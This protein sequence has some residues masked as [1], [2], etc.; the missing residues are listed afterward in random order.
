[1]SFIEELEN[2]DLEIPKGGLSAKIALA[3]KEKRPLR[4]KLGLDPTK[5]D[6]HLGH[7]VVLRVL[8]KFLKI[9]AKIFLVV[10]DFTAMIGDPSGRDKTRPPLTHQEIQRNAQTYVEQ[11]GRVL[12]TSKI[13]VVFNST[14]LSKISLE[15]FIKIL[16][17]FNLSEILARDDFKQRFNGGFPIAMHE[18]IYPLMQAYDSYYLK[19]DVEIGG[20]DQLFNMQMGRSLQEAFA[21]SAQVIITTPLLIGIDGVNK[22]SKSLNNYIAITEE[23]KDIYAKILAIP[24]SLIPD[25]LKLV[26]DLPKAKKRELLARL[27]KNVNPFL[28]KKEIAFQIVCQFYDKKAA[29][30][31][32]EYFYRQFEEED[33]KKKIY[34]KKTFSDL[35]INKEKFTLLDLVFA[36][37]VRNS[38]SEARR[39]ILQG[40]VSV[41]GEK[42]KD[43]YFIFKN[44][45]TPLFI[46]AG[47]K[48]FFSIS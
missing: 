12:D 5:P 21:E 36:L 22:M 3:K 13:E 8:R 24:D 29:K 43:P 33:I 4:V 30:D 14:W 35:G 37:G 47:Q 17:K 34:L 10:G 20:S 1:M 46:R 27:Q 48:D 38:K 32:E 44:P 11:L 15:N 2:I 26:C 28:I 40:A 45:K 16:A 41:N 9:G 39:L 23:P 25:Y 7:Y 42:I 18:L 6:I 31:S 19:A